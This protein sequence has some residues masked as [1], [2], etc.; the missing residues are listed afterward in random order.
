MK[1]LSIVTAIILI[2]DINLVY[3][4]DVPD[5]MNKDGACTLI[6][7]RPDTSLSPNK[8][9]CVSDKNAM[10]DQNGAK[11]VTNDSSIHY[12]GSKITENG[13]EVTIYREENGDFIAIHPDKKPPNH[14]RKGKTLKGVLGFEKIDKNE[15]RADPHGGVDHKPHKK[16]AKQTPSIKTKSVGMAGIDKKEG[17]ADLHGGV[18]H[19]PHKKTAKQTPSIKTKSVGM[20]GI[21][22]KEGGADLHGGVDHKPHKKIA[23]QAPN[24]K[25]E[26]VDTVVLGGKAFRIAKN[27]GGTDLHGAVDHTPHKNMSNTK[28]NSGSTAGLVKNTNGTDKVFATITKRG[29]KEKI[30]VYKAT[31]GD[32]VTYDKDG[33]PVRRGSGKS[34]E[35]I[36]KAENHEGPISARDKYR[37]ELDKWKRAEAAR[38]NMEA[39]EEAARQG[40]SYKKAAKQTPNQTLNIKTK[41]GGVADL[42]KNADGTDKVFATITKRG[43]KEKIKVYKATNGDWVTYD[44]DGG[45]VR[46][47]SGKSLEDIFKAENHEGPISARDKYR[48]ELDKWKRAEAARKNMEAAEE[49]AREKARTK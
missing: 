42:V 45:S 46:R 22:K 9:M 34:L 20:A 33:G 16:T 38:K 26:S 43:T 30:K 32:W 18:D 15:R 23:K 7:T 5:T 4:A 41:S 10:S 44:K 8:C 25:K 13:S 19:K 40:K 28:I 27:A 31:N 49:A 24:I 35:D 36:F 1:S 6:C 48:I 2:A 39:A 29:T 3:S 12:I 37:I 17:G 14:Y 21:D 11:P 47:G